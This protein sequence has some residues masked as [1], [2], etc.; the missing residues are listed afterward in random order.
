MGRKETAALV[1]LGIVLCLVLVS[2]NVVVTAD[3]TVLDADFVKD[4]A[5]EEGLYEAIAEDLRDG[6]DEGAADD[7]GEPGPSEE[8]LFQEALTDEYVQ[9]QV[10]AN[11]D[12]FYEFLHGERDD[13]RLEMDTEPLKQNVLEE[14]EAEIQSAD[15]EELG[16]PEGDAIEEMAASESQFEAHR[17]DFRSQEKERIQAE[18]ERELDDDEL[19]ETLEE[20]MDEI[21][22]QLRAEMEAELDGEFA[23]ADADPAMEAAVRALLNARIDALTGERSYD[24]YVDEVDAARDDLDDALVAQF[25]AEIDEE[26]PDAIDFTEG[27]DEEAMEMFETAQTA[28]SVLGAL[29]ILLPLLALAVAGT[30]AWVAPASVAALTIGGLSAFVGVIGTVGSWIATGQIEAFVAA[31]GIDPQIADFLVGLVSGV[32]GT[33]LWQSVLLLVVG[34]GLVAVGIGIRRDLLLAEYE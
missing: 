27:M 12:R 9:T 3:R 31:E 16:I 33:L 1:G 29:A 20:E 14:L 17:E 23:G 30:I 8:A 26:M 4:T 22:E 5:E 34:I 10:E 18:T 19:E 6:F 7:G 28:V 13:L 2:A 24:E 15:L 32:L 11:V 25:E 21:R